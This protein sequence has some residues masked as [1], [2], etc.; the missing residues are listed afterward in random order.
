MCTRSPKP[1]GPPPLTA[2]EKKQLL[3]I[4]K[5]FEKHNTRYKVVISPIYNQ[6]P[7]EKEQIELLE[8]IFGKEYIYN[9]SGKNQFTEPLHNF[10]ETS[11]YRPHVANEIMKKIYQK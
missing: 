9:F 7:M 4:K 8:Q 6:V 10:Y 1:A 3:A 2:E 11:H 5:I